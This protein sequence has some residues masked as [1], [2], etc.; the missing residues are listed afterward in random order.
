[1]LYLDT[2]VLLVAPLTQSVE[3]VRAVDFFPVYCLRAMPSPFAGRNLRSRSG[4][5]LG[6]R[7][8]VALDME[9]YILVI[10][11]QSC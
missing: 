8:G 4:L 6:D 10:R 1:M 9:P 3:R 2:L 5:V 7:E 11:L